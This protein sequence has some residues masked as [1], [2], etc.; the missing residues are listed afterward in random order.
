MTIRNETNTAIVAKYGEKIES[1]SQRQFLEHIFDTIHVH[2][3][4]G[5][6]EITCEYGSRFFKNYGKII[7]K[8]ETEIDTEKRKIVV[9]CPLEENQKK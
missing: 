9:I 2:C 4:D 1:G 7:G 6:V 3:D 5:S 8:E